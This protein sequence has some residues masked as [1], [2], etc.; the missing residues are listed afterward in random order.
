MNLGSLLIPFIFLAFVFLIG[1][2]VIISFQNKQASRPPL[3]RESKEGTSIRNTKPDE[4]P[5]WLSELKS[6]VETGDEPG[7]FEA[8]PISEQIE[9]MANR[10]LKA[11]PDLRGVNLD[12]GT[13]IEG[14]LEIWVNSERYSSI[15]EI[16]D[17]RIR[18]A[19][20]EA[21]QEYNR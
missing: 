5:E 10:L 15:E 3:I 20:N 8:S 18:N 1:F 7:E 2:L 12:F 16:P 9:E 13:A 6:V 21:V 11:H 14:S 19:I 17:E 4:T